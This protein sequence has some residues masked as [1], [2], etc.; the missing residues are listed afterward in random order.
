MEAITTELCSVFSSQVR[1][2]SLATKDG[3]WEPTTLDLN[4]HF[5]QE[6]AVAGQA[7]AQRLV[8]DIIQQ[9]LDHNFPLWRVHVV[10][11]QDRRG[12]SIVVLRIHHCIGDGFAI[13]SIFHSLARSED[14]EPVK[15]TALMRK[16]ACERQHEQQTCSLATACN[17]VAQIGRAHV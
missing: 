14:G 7:D 2:R 9:D 6:E 11:V 5:V 15:E 8:E 13:A 17:G 16:L 10:P 1:F 3:T 12:L 4:Y